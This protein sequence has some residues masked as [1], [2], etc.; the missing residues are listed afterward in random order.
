VI[1]PIIFGKFILLERISVGGMA[2]VYRAK[3][4]NQ[5]DFGR[6]FAI[7]RILPNLAAD[8]EF[9][10]MFINEAKVAVELEHPNVCQIYELG[11]LG[12][13]HY[14]A[15]E[16]IS[17]RDV[18]A[19]QNHYR[20]Q[21]KIMSVSQACFIAAQ[22]AQGLDY[23][24]RAVDSSGHPL[25]LIHRDVSPHN[26]LIS[27]DGIVKLIDFGVA[28]ASQKTSN[29]QSGVF[30]GKFSYMS[31]EQA[32][33]GIID[34]RSDIFAMGVVFWELLTGRRLFNSESEFAIIDMISNCE[35]DRPSKYNRLIPDNVDRICMRALERDPARRYQFAGEMVV[36]LYDFIN[37]C[38]P[39]YTLWH[40]E[41]W[42]QTTF[43][44]IFERE[45]SRER[46]FEGINTPQDIEQYNKENA[47]RQQQEQA[48]KTLDREGNAIPEIESVDS[49]EAEL[50][51]A[52]YSFEE[53]EA[54]EREKEKGAKGPKL[55][56]VPGRA[57][58]GE[59]SKSLP[60]VKALNLS[61]LKS[62]RADGSLSEKI[63][64]PASSPAAP[65]LS[66]NASPSINEDDIE[67]EPE[68][69][70]P[71]VSDPELLRLKRIARRSKQRRRLT[72]SII[73]TCFS[74]LVVVILVLTGN[75]GIPAPEAVLPT[76]ADL[77]IEI[78][79]DTSDARVMLYKHPKVESDAPL[80]TANGKKLTFEGLDAGRYAIDVDMTGYEL[81]SFTISIELGMSETR[82]EMTQALPEDVFYKVFVSPEDAALYVDGHL[83]E[84]EGSER[85]L[86]GE[87]GVSH[88][89]EVRRVGYATQQQSVT[90]DKDT[91]LDF[92][93]EE[94]RGSIA[95]KS[96]PEGA[97][98]FVEENGRMRDK[99]S[100]PLVLSDLDPRVP[101]KV[102]VRRRGHETWKRTIDFSHGSDVRY[103]VDLKSE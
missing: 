5:P 15:M 13:S 9:V 67:L 61:G 70:A 12:Q 83:V 53:A 28:K 91:I 58:P 44:D 41:T 101:L 76:Q 99:G 26:L 68:G 8:K 6:Y 95:F 25:G 11:R 75:I 3:L 35:I 31:P 79:P 40:L 4:L 39:P 1:R 96:E 74:L 65:R 88:V 24:H 37:S 30:K 33:N 34:H 10:T 2:E 71:T 7:K 32:T 100:T 49:S 89:V 69:I 29:T 46:I 27:F 81:E 54:R 85:T 43:A 48:S 19:I 57:K 90:L 92:A 56:P 17:G 72:M 47:A 63:H 102:E 94:V 87:L 78:V 21:R 82:L 23:A 86:F 18:L 64:D 51:S 55:P 36:E 45:K 73:G 16:Y 50:Y 59:T 22:A 97:S 98:V 52:E 14:I 20:R 80:R 77:M 103:F 62:A 42:L 84:G 60:G 66:I 38:D 93:L